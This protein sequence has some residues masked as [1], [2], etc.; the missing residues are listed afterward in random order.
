MMK[1]RLLY[2]FIIFLVC[3]L[4]LNAHEDEQHE[5]EE[6]ETLTTSSLT[7][8]W[9]VRRSGVCITDEDLKFH[10]AH[11]VQRIKS[12]LVLHFCSEDDQLF[13]L[14]KNRN[15][16]QNAEAEYQVTG[17][18]IENGSFVTTFNITAQAENGAELNFDLTA[19]DPKKE[20]RITVYF[21]DD[22]C[23]AIAKRIKAK[24]S[25]ACKQL[26]PV[27]TIAE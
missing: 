24:P 22:S 13:G 14:V 23:G 9:K 25:R 21:Q 18:T 27:V 16:L 20:K 26:L 6:V 12:K 10:T 11:E 3:S 15:R 19:V 4:S 2:S 8:V 17:S 1:I 7:G 5:I